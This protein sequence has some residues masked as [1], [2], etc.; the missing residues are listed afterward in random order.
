MFCSFVEACLDQTWF[1]L[2]EQKSTVMKI[3]EIISEAT[4]CDEFKEYC[5]Q[6]CN[7]GRFPPQL[8]NMW[9]FEARADEALYKQFFLAEIRKHLKDHLQN[10]IVLKTP[11][12]KQ[13]LDGNST[14]F[15]TLINTGN[16][17]WDLQNKELG[18][19]E[20]PKSYLPN[21]KQ[22]MSFIWHALNSHVA[23]DHQSYQKN[24]SFALHLSTQPAVNNRDFSQERA[25]PDPKTMESSMYCFVA[26]KP[27]TKKQDPD[28]FLTGDGHFVLCKRV[29]RQEV[30]NN[31]LKENLAPYTHM[32]QIRE[33]TGSDVSR[34]TGI[35]CLGD[36]VSVACTFEDIN[37]LFKVLTVRK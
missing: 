13:Q 23:F 21:T 12:E 4:A 26:N 36:P 31:Y 37:K 6:E 18:L 20:P 17:V 8:I 28:R 15:Q 16:K 32:H 11:D 9:F 7:N 27:N 30:E 1:R 14:E 5:E 24:K 33:L 25:K 19:D 2:S 35:K 3:S 22:N 29:R 34:E 10:N